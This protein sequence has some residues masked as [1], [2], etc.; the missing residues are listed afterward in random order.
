ATFN[1]K[2]NFFQ[3]KIGFAISLRSHNTRYILSNSYTTL[4]HI[5]DSLLLTCSFVWKGA[6]NYTIGCEDSIGN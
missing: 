6:A 1:Q 3:F 4:R 2:L 5:D